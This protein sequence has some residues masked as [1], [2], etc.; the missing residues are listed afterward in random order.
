[1]HFTIFGVD[2]FLGKLLYNY[3]SS[4]YG[5]KITFMLVSRYSKFKTDNKDN[6]TLVAVNDMTQ[7]DIDYIQYSDY[8]VY[9][10]SELQFKNA[11][12]ANYYEHIV[13]L[14][15][16]SNIFKSCAGKVVFFSD[17]YCKTSMEDIIADYL[18][19][20]RDET[21][22]LLTGQVSS[23]ANFFG[24][25][26]LYLQYIYDRLLNNFICNENVLVIKNYTISYSK[27]SS[28]I[29]TKQDVKLY[30]KYWKNK[31]AIAKNLVKKGLIKN[32]YSLSMNDFIGYSHDLILSSKVGIVLCE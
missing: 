28:L 30:E 11:N 7:K 10:M 23:R 24:D 25:S 27:E 17:S 13:H 9:T 4:Y 19:D 32:M 31:E 16:Y 8:V 21:E 5:T 20:I 29:K 22:S 14:M 18:F 6:F 2:T 12:T 1:M 26:I 3:L 15:D